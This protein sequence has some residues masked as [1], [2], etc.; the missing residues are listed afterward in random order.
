MTITTPSAAPATISDLPVP[1]QP[2]DT[3]VH[4]MYRTKDANN[5][6]KDETNTFRVYKKSNGNYKV[7][8]DYTAMDGAVGHD[9]RVYAPDGFGGYTL[10]NKDGS[11][12]PISIFEITPNA[13]GVLE[14]R[15]NINN[16]GHDDAALYVYNT[17]IQ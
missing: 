17:K 5:D 13:F 7:T 11:Q 3:L 6:G 1:Q 16:D 2:V 14:P 15:I 12:N 8:E 10:L 4:T 9:E